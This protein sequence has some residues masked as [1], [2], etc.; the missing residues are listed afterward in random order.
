MVGPVTI[1]L[2]QTIEWL[3]G[4]RIEFRR[5]GAVLLLR[6]LAKTVPSL[7][8][9]HIPDLLDNLWTA[10]RDPK[11]AIREV[12]AGALSG[13]LKIAYDRDGQ[14]RSEWY[15]MVY[16]QAAKGFK[17]NTADAIHGSLLGYQELFQRAGM[18][19]PA[20]FNAWF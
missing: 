8:Y 13:C 16:D 1:Q 7:M 4:E 14:L 17:L 19:R 3:Q 2:K 5:W 10:L 9:E 12:A 11:V 18:V 15:S 6:E 20:T